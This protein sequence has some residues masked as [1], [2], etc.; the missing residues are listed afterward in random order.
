MRGEPFPIPNPLGVRNLGI[1]NPKEIPDQ[2]F[3][4][5]CGKL[6]PLP[7]DRERGYHTRCASAAGP[8]VD[9]GEFWI[10]S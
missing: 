2:A 1:E 7:E 3:C 8:P 4:S 9:D 5:V 10:D 6:L